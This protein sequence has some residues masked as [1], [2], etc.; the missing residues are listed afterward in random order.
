MSPESSVMVRN[1]STVSK[2]RWV[3]ARVLQQTGPVSY[4]CA[5]PEGN[6]VRRHQDQILSRSMS[7]PIKTFQP[8]SEESTHSPVVPES[9]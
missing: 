6:V 5:L 8:L 7:S 2:D 9:R 4:K 1:Y 3:P